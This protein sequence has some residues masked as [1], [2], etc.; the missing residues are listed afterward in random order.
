VPF[1]S[2]IHLST[3]VAINELQKPIFRK[4]FRGKKIPRNFHAGN[5]AGKFL[6]KNVRKIDLGL[7]KSSSILNSENFYSCT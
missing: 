4:K 2:F 5:S 1:L 7:K 6:G 3:I